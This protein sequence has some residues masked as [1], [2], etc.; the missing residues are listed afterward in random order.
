MSEFLV[1]LGTRIGVFCVEDPK[2]R[3]IG[4]TESMR[5]SASFPKVGGHLYLTWKEEMLRISPNQNAPSTFPTTHGS[6][7]QSIETDVQLPVF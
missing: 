7:F 4:N 5:A 2:G 6:H 1:R 3:T